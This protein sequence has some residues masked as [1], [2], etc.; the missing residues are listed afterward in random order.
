[1]PL[2]TWLDTLADAVDEAIEAM[3]STRVGYAQDGDDWR[4]V[5][6]PA[7]VR[8][9]GGSDDVYDLIKVDLSLVLPLFTADTPH[10]CV[11]VNCAEDSVSVE[12]LYEGHPVWLEIRFQ[13]ADDAPAMILVHKDGSFE[14]IDEARSLS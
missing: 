5:I 13:P 4:V 2:P 14:D 12:G 6:E 1:M 8:F 9:D 10:D 3:Y 11:Q 7:R